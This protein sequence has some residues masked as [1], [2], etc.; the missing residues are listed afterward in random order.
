MSI[1]DQEVE[2]ACT[3]TAKNGVGVPFVIMRAALTAAANAR[4]SE[5]VGVSAEA[6]LAIRDALLSDDNLLAWLDG[7]TPNEM[8]DS[9][10]RLKDRAEAAEQQLKAAREALE[11]IADIAHRNYGRQN[12]KLADIEPIALRAL[13]PIPEVGE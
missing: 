8:H 13:N 3:E 11:Q 1:S 7:L 2:A 9:I 5:G 10:V 6:L 4:K 12:K